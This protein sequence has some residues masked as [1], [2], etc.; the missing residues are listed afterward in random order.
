MTV[1]EEKIPDQIR[2]TVM[3]HLLD[4]FKTNCLVRA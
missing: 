4:V 3:F 2:A 1:F